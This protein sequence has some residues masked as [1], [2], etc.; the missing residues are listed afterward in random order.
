MSTNNAS[1]KLLKASTQASG[2]GVQHV[3]V[4][5]KPDGSFNMSGSD[6]IINAIMN[7][8]ALYQT[9]RRTVTANWQEEGEVIPVKV[10]S[11]PRLPCSPFSKAW[12]GS[13]MIRGQLDSIV[14]AAGFGK[15]GLKL[16]QG[17]PPQGWP[18]DL[19]W[20]GYKGSGRSGL[21]NTQMTSIIVSMLE[22]ANIDPATHVRQEDAGGDDVEIGEEQIH[23]IGA[24]DEEI[25]L[26]VAGEEEIPVMEVGDEQ[27]H[28]MGAGEEQIDGIGTGEEQINI[29]DIECVTADETADTDSAYEDIADTN[30]VDS[31]TADVETLDY[32]PT[33]DYTSYNSAN[34]CDHNYIDKNIEDLVSLAKD[35]SEFEKAENVEEN[36]VEN[37]SKKNRYI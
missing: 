14:T 23:V 15:Y 25:P 2:K 3:L 22:S 4:I 29:M 10:L 19:E 35:L 12:K 36:S 33:A 9:L 30:N 5:V 18:Q 7:D 20:L 28:S 21:S 11:F 6:N 17:D 1:K 13:A 16:G 37:G 31:D 24:G 8:A 34:E 32:V 26:M 27:I